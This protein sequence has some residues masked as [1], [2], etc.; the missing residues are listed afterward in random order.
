MTKL[1]GFFSHRKPEIYQ[2]RSR[3][4]ISNISAIDLQ[5]ENLPIWYN[6]NR[7]YPNN[8]GILWKAARQPFS[9]FQKPNSFYG[10]PFLNEMHYD[11]RILISVYPPDGHFYE[12]TWKLPH[13]DSSYRTDIVR[14]TCG[15]K[16]MFTEQILK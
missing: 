13:G 11:R 14:L 1:N 9:P 16:N 15:F 6:F 5:N 7:S 4:H 3:R 8:K 2:I 10:K 12:K